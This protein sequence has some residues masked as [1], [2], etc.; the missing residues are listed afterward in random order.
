M[1]LA[2]LQD[3]VD[4][5][6]AV[7]A[8]RPPEVG[9]QVAGQ[10]GGRPMRPVAQLQAVAEDDEPVHVPHRLE[11]G[12]AQ[13]RPPQEVVERVGAEMEVRDHQRPHRH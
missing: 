11:Q 13:L 1:L 4:R 6:L 7:P 10:L 12:L 2:G 8:E 9:E 3:W 5:Q